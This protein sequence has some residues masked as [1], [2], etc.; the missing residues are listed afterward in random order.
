MNEISFDAELALG[1][2]AALEQVTEALK[3]E[4]FGIISRIDLHATFKKKLGVNMTPH[5]I[6]DACN[7]ELAHK[8]VSTAPEAA[9]ML[10]C[11]VTVQPLAENRTVVRI[12]NPGPMMAGADLNGN[13]AVREVGTEA[14]TRLKRVAEVLRR[15]S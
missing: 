8:A 4:G 10:P 14:E 7:P 6:L 11:N 2:D 12:V 5:T 13:P 3:A 1:F 15:A 9:L